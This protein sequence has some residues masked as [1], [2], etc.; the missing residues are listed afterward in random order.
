[1]Y[2]RHKPSGDLVEVM[3]L[4]ALFD[5][6][7]DAIVGR[8]HAGEELQDPAPFAKSDLIFPSGEALPRCWLD[9]HYR[10]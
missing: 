5:P 9:V 7:K 4:A 1:M 8:F 2:L 10:S 3:D 6:N